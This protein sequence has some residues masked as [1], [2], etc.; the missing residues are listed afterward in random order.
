VKRAWKSLSEPRKKTPCFLGV[1]EYLE[2]K[3]E[4]EQETKQQPNN[5]YWIST[6][7][8]IFFLTVSGAFFNQ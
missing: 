1:E 8:F 2:T 5:R 3:Q 7:L 6:T 4:T